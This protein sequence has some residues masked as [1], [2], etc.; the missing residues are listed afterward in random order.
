MAIRSTFTTGEVLTAADLTDTIKG[1]FI[2]TETTTAR[3]LGTADA[4]NLVTL[5]NNSGGTVTIPTNTTWGSPLGTLVHLINIGTAGSFTV[6]TAAGVTLNAAS[7]TMAIQEGGTLIKTATNTWQFV[8]GGGLGKA[9]YSS[10]T[11]SPTVTTVSGKTCVQFTGSG[12]I[13]ISQAG[14]LEILIVGAGAGGSGTSGTRGGGGGAGGYLAASAVYLDAGTHT[15]VTGAGAPGGAAGSGQ[16]GS[17]NGGTSRIG[18]YYAVGGGGAESHTT[19]TGIVGNTGGSGG[20]GSGGSAGGSGTS[21]QGNDGGTSSGTNGG[22]GGGGASAVGANAVTT[23]GGAGGAGTASSITG[24]SVTRAGGGGGAG[25]VTGGAGGTG[26]GGAGG[27]G[28]VNGTAGG[29]NT[30]GGGGGGTTNGGAGGSG[31]VILLFG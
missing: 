17:K 5:N 2:N 14:L 10:T 6:G 18:P 21:G 31:I 12:S 22:G 28:A 23:T 15:V 9:Q 19:T 20:G 30:G 26:G 4:G 3:T 24:S 11:G 13:T 27:G 8:K 1:A 7:A 29:A 25:S 16:E